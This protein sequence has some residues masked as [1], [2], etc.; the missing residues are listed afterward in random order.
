[1][2]RLASGTSWTLIVLCWVGYYVLWAIGGF[3]PFG[4]VLDA[5]QFPRGEPLV[6]LAWCISMIVGATIG[7]MI[8]AR[9]PRNPIGWLVFGATGMVSL[10]T[11][12]DEYGVMP[13]VRPEVD[14]PAAIWLVW[15]AGGVKQG[16]AVMALLLLLFPGGRLLSNRWLP[17][18]WIAVASGL[19]GALGRALIAGPLL[20]G[21]HFANPLGLLV[22]GAWPFVLLTGGTVLAALA[23]LGG[24]A[25]LI[26]R[27][28]RAT[29]HERLQL[30]WIA[31][32]A[33][34]WI[35]LLVLNSVA[36]DVIAVRVLMVSGAGAFVVAL[37]AGVL[38]YRLYD[39]DVVIN[40]ALVYGALTVCVIGMYIVVVA[41]VSGV[42]RSLSDTVVSLIA[43]GLVAVVF[44][45]LR[46]QLQRLANRLVYGYRASPYESWRRFR[47]ASAKPFPSMRSSP[48]LPKPPGEVWERRKCVCGCSAP[49]MSSA[50][51]CGLRVHRNSGSTS[52]ACPCFIAANSSARLPLPN[53]RVKY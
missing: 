12:A 40:K 18:A 48:A 43:T 33:T 39:V 19:L 38:R 37:G 49:I 44:Q 2:A 47:G 4:P 22:G 27:Y 36:R 14:W 13:L 29:S 45:P 10:F 34:V 20:D 23:L 26:V 41:A 15:F 17:L 3:G 9:H 11:L 51:S 24:G 35:P 21:P 8:V 5:A 30:K 42:V 50:P 25:S 6:M 32:A 52:A 7:L 16:T 28:R 53:H 1:V 31:L 46:D